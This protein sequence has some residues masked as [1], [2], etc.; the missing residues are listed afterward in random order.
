MVNKVCVAIWDS[1]EGNTLTK[2]NYFTKE[3]GG[4]ICYSTKITDFHLCQKTL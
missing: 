3:L 2:Y 4:E 1:L